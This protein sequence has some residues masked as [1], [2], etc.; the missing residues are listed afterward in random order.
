M[1]FLMSLWTA[2]PALKTQLTV[3][4]VLL[5]MVIT[6]WCYTHMSKARVRAAKSGEVSPDIY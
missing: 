5:Q 3:F 6:I 2:A 1:E 4:A